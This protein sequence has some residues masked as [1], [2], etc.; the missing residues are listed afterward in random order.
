[1]LEAPGEFRL[2]QEAALDVRRPLAPERF[3]PQR[4]DRHGS[5]DVRIVREEDGAHRPLPEDPG[6]LKPA[7]L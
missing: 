1:M 2:P 4:L 6:D 3:V 5:L 7:E